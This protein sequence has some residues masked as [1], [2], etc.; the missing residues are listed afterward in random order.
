MEPL[1]DYYM[2]EAS[3]LLQE[4]PPFYFKNCHQSRRTSPCAWSKQ[5]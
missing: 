4:L 5:M 1:L 2:Q 3:L